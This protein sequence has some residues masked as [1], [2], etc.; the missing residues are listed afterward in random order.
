MRLLKKI[1]GW[2]SGKDAVINEQPI[3]PQFTSDKEPSEEDPLLEVIDEALAE[4]PETPLAPT[5][6]EVR[7]G[8]K[9]YIVEDLTSDDIKKLGQEW[10]KRKLKA[11]GIIR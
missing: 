3:A 6:T 8:R 9:T 4:E 11:V 1:L 7:L 2:N 5:K 10:G